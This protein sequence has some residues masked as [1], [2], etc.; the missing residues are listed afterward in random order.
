VLVPEA[1]EIALLAKQPVRFVLLVGVRAGFD[2]GQNFLSEP[3]ADFRPQ[4]GGIAVGLVL[5]GVMQQSGELIADYADLKS[6]GSRGT[7]AASHRSPQPQVGGLG[8][9]SPRSSHSGALPWFTISVALVCRTASGTNP[10]IL[11]RCSRGEGVVHEA[12]APKRDAPRRAAPSPSSGRR[13]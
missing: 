6:R 7:L 10:E 3:A 5:D 8:Y 2:D 12:R 11:V 9:P 1:F 4:P 13:P